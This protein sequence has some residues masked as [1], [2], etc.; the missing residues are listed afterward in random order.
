MKLV[1]SEFVVLHTYDEYV[2]HEQIIKGQAINPELTRLP[3]QPESMQ[4]TLLDVGVSA[5][6][7]STWTRSGT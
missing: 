5:V 1:E 2:E 6:Q 3:V 7:S 4:L